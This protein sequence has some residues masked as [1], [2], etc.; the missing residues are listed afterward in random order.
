M[1]NLHKKGF[2]ALALLLFFFIFN[3]SSVEVLA[4]PEFELN[5]K[6]ALLMEAESGKII[7]EKNAHQKLPPASMTKVMTMLLVMEALEEG[8]VSLDDKIVTSPYAARMGGSQIWLEPGEEMILEDMLKAIA[9]VS[10][11][12]ASVAV[13]EHVAGSAETFI[14]QMNQRAEELG[15]KNTYFY[16]TN[17]L[18]VTVANIQGNYS[19]AFD[20]AVAARE[21]LKYPQI[22]E[23]TSI[24]HEYIR[25]GQ[26]VLNNTNRLVR[27]LPGVDGLKTGYT[28]EAGHGVVATA[29]R[30]DLRFI[31]VIMACERSETRFDEAAQLLNHGF[32]SY[33]S[34]TVAEADEVIIEIEL[35]NANVDKISVTVPEK[36]IVP[37]PREEEDMVS[38]KIEL[39]DNISAPLDIGDKVGELD[40]LVK[41]HL[42]KEVDLVA[43]QQ[44]DKVSIF[45]MIFRVFFNL[46]NEFITFLN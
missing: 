34:V 39:D 7:F 3:I 22:L 35:K 4:Q 2:L 18:P 6:S 25:E 24:W 11:N 42:I 15:M 32:N 9:I 37:V 30:D 8:R 33:T 17:G 27:H 44:A 43:A 23:Y 26:S 36:I 13:A 20:L 29:A 38:T 10:A 46:M 1:F 14:E 31:A 16:N 5:A 40:I 41:D 12:D 19:T 21:L 45:G 28:S